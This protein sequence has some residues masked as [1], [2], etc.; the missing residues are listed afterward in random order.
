M[1][2]LVRRLWRGALIVLWMVGIYPPQAGSTVIDFEQDRLPPET[3]RPA[4][5]TDQ[6]DWVSQGVRFNR[7]WNTEYGC[8]PSGWAVSNQTDQSTAGPT[9]AFSAYVAGT[10]GGGRNSTQFGVVNN[11]QRGEAR[12]VFAQPVMVE[13]MYITNV[14]YT[15]LA[16]VTGDDGAGFVKGPFTAGDWLR[17]DVVGLDNQRTE[18]GR[19]PYF[20]I[21]YRDGLS[22]AVA[23]WTWLDLSPLG[24]EVSSL[25]FEMS[26]TD[27]GDFGMN[28][29]AYFAVDDLT[30]RV[31]PEPAAG[32]LVSW[33]LLLVRAVKRKRQTDSVVP[34]SSRALCAAAGNKTR[35]LE[36]DRRLC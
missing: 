28:T 14:T 27:S 16:T 17:L 33:A 26:S 31:V 3:A 4:T 9:S 2:K 25:E 8:C 11:F 1:H 36:L 19:V 18:T 24:S 12:V 21:D 7:D 5:A 20:L 22:T 13:G 6:S 32:T 29:P 15:Y 35:W 23:A 10:N 34:P 30:F